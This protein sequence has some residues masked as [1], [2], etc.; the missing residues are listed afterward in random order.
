[1]TLQPS[2][3]GIFIGENLNVGF[4]G[5]GK[6]GLMVALSIESRGHEVKGYDINPAVATYL[7]ERKIPFKEENSETLLANTRMEMVS[8]EALCD[9]ADILFLAPQTPHAPQYEGA[10]PLPKERVDFDYTYLIECVK[11]VNA[12]LKT[13][14]L[15]V[16]ISTVLPGTLD[17]EVLPII[18]PNF[19]LVYE[20]LFIA[21]GTVYRDF[22]NPE[23]VLMGVNDPAAADEL[24]A[25]YKTIHGKPCFK[26][27]IRTA[28]GIKVGYN[29]FIT[30]K[31]VFANFWGELAH[32]TGMNIDDFTRA[33]SMAGD[34]IMSS[35]YMNAGMGDG[36]GCHPRDNIAL[37]YI[38]KKHRLAFDLPEA[39]MVAREKH[40][41]WLADLITI[42]ACNLNSNLKMPPVYILGRAFKPETNIETGSPAVLLSNLLNMRHE[43]VE[44][45]EPR[46][47]GVYFI[48][49]KHERY[50]SY[51]FPEGSTVIDPF[52]YLPAQDGIRLVSIGKNN[53][54]RQSV[55]SDLAEQPPQQREYANQR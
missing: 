55:Q 30:L 38:A 51:K 54:N 24:E 37:S 47:R 8:L 18:G 13:P 14:K 48:A 41:E 39:L 6:L 23:F 27:D 19:R 50:K 20:P 2:T 45:M 1:L 4:I 34:R 52:R 9:W 42:E 29:T 31:T 22:L 33:L 17:R 5:T 28:E 35:K 10:T 46:R 7:K 15:C 44:D 25:F 16:I 40:C 32:K 43:T 36:G 3:E 11:N 12:Y 26:T 21:M 49:T 53:G